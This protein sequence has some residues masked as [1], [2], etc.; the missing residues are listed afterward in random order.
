MRNIVTNTKFSDCLIHFIV[1]QNLNRTAF[2][3]EKYQESK[4]HVNRFK[5][6]ITELKIREVLTLCTIK[7]QD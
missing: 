4:N 3:T 1:F 5:M 6:F 7:K 2:Q